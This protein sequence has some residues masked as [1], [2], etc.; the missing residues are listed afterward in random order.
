MSEKERYHVAPLPPTQVRLAYPLLQAVHPD[1]S[2]DAWLR[3]ATDIG[4][5]A[6][7]T[8]DCG[9]MVLRSCGDCLFGLFTYM[10]HPHL[11]HGRV[12]EVDNLAL[13]DLANRR[14]T[15][16]VLLDEIERMARVREC[17]GIH[18]R[19]Q[20]GHDHLFETARPSVTHD[21][22]HCDGRAR[23]GRWMCRQL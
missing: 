4:R 5:G 9:V 23:P 6:E 8:Q 13:L 16:R 10:V 3:F 12:L 22:V 1:A 21:T 2:L 7:E 18:Y 17:G 19:I 11:Q 15:T 14:S 20:A